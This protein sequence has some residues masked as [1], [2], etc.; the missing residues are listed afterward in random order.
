MPRHA[1]AGSLVSV[2]ALSRSRTSSVWSPA[3]GAHG[4]HWSTQGRS[5]PPVDLMCNPP[6]DRTPSRRWTGR[7]DHVRPRPRITFHDRRIPFIDQASRTENRVRA[8]VQVDPLPV[9]RSSAAELVTA[10]QTST[11][12]HPTP[13]RTP[14]L[15]NVR[16]HPAPPSVEASTVSPS[17]TASQRCWLGQATAPNGRVTRV[18]SRF[19]TMPPSRVSKTVPASPTATQRVGVGQATPKR[20]WSVGTLIVDQVRPA[21]RLTWTPP[22]PPTATQVEGVGQATESSAAGGPAGREGLSPWVAVDAA[23]HAAGTKRRPTTSAPWA[24]KRRTHR[25]WDSGRVPIERYCPSRLTIT[26]VVQHLGRRHSG[27]R[28]LR[29]PVTST[30]FGSASGTS[31]NTSISSRRSASVTTLRTRSTSCAA[32]LRATARVAVPRCRSASA[33]H[34]PHLHRGVLRLDPFTRAALDRSGRR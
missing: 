3:S 25:R 21:V 9:V 33:R 2:T 10:V 4:R 14:D 29:R 11:V 15:E 34:A 24:R 28:L 16:R 5:P 12:L 13:S 22:A 19:H 17:P 26:P 31:R 8:D 20:K 27:H 7:R 23:A 18:F 32:S 1:R 6:T 30:Y